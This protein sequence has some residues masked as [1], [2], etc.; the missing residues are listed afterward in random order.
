MQKDIRLP[1][2]TIDQA[3]EILNVSKYIFETKLRYHLTRLQR[4]NGKDV[5][6][7]EEIRALDK[8]IVRNSFEI[9]S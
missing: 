9:I 2:F 3:C 1:V 8:I 5:F 6:L 7:Q 4:I